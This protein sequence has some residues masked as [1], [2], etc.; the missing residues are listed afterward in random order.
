VNM[1]NDPYYTPLKDER[2]TDAISC[3]ENNQASE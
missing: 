2:I 3:M 1:M